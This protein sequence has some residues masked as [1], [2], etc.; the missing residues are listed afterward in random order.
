M[1]A[2]AD[3]LIPVGK[4][5]RP[6]GLQGE[7]R[8]FPDG[9]RRLIPELPVKLRA[10]YGTAKTE[11]VTLIKF[12]EQGNKHRIR[13]AGVEDRENADCYKNMHLFIEEEML[14]E[15]GENEYYFYELKGLAVLSESG[16][17]LGTVYDVYELPTTE[18]LEI[19]LFETGKVIIPFREEWVLSVSTESGEITVDRQKLQELL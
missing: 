8:F 9:N 13:L 10:G 3:R 2:E 15:I 5:G 7:M 16:R 6:A 17:R 1:T 18:A 4:I 14:P 12:K 11:V 19:D